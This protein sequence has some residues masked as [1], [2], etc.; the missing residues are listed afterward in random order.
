M[1]VIKTS[2]LLDES[3]PIPYVFCRSP[4]V[5]P[6]ASIVPSR[7]KLPPP[8]PPSEHGTIECNGLHRC[9]GNANHATR[10][11]T[12]KECRAQHCLRRCLCGT[13]YMV[14]IP[15]W[16]CTCLTD[17]LRNIQKSSCSRCG[18]GQPTVPPVVS[19]NHVSH[20]YHVDMGMDHTRDTV[21]SSNSE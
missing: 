3:A 13:V 9:T 16:F 17:S 19:G 8:N 1:M 10:R 12:C 20:T 11:E 14:L 7:Q 18:I 6:A 4:K 5:P 21:I 2:N 15:C